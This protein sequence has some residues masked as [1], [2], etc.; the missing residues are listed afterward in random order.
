MG[1]PPLKA[2]LSGG[3]ATSHRPFRQVIQRVAADIEIG[4]SLS[5]ALAPHPLA[6]STLTVQVLQVAERGGVLDESLRLVAEELERRVD[7]R[8]R[9]RGLWRIHRPSWWWA[10]GSAFVLAYVVPEFMVNLSIPN[11]LSC[12]YSHVV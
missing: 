1:V 12:Q 11:K 3:R 7:I 10:G 4:N 2:L 8:G 5:E 9:V 6:F